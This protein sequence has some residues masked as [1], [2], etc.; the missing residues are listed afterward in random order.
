M[1]LDKN[2]KKEMT[3]LVV[4]KADAIIERAKKLVK[5]ALETKDAVSV[6]KLAAALMLMSGIRA[7]FLLTGKIVVKPGPTSYSIVFK[8]NPG[9]KNWDARPILCESSLF[10]QGATLMKSLQKDTFTTTEADAIYKKGIAEQIRKMVLFEGGARDATTGDARWVFVALCYKKHNYSQTG[11]TK[12]E[13]ANWISAS[14]KHNALMPTQEI[15]LKGN[16]STFPEK[17]RTP[18]PER[19]QRRVARRL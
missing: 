7:G 12:Q 9:A 19:Y 1:S 18:L 8:P 4:D 5:T 10:V 17:N 6:S 2:N 11:I 13:F 15:V 16:V 14:G 3:K